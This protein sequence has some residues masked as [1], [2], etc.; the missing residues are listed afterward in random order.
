MPQPSAEGDAVG[1]VDVDAH[2]GRGRRV[3]GRGAQRLAEAG[4]LQHQIQRDRGDDRDGAGDQPRLVQEHRG[5][6]VDRSDHERAGGDSGVRTVTGRRAEHDQPA[7]LQDQR[8]AEGDD[9]LAEMAIVD[10]CPRCAGRRRGDQELVQQRAA[11][12]HDR[13]GAERADER[14]DIGAE[15][16]EHAA[17]GHQIEAGEHAQHQQLALGEVDD[18][19]DAEDQ[20][21][22]DA[23]QAVDAA[24]GDAG[25]ERVQHVL[26]RTSRSTG[27]LMPPVRHRHPRESGDPDCDPGSPLS[28]G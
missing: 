14:A 24:D 26:D 4:V 6:A 28:R 22:A 7:V 3:V 8:D 1:A 10:R 2:V 21:E 17:A 18:A 9:K 5:V 19:H 13:P 15:E 27:F 11:G 12:E 23:H 25:G 20:P 16:G